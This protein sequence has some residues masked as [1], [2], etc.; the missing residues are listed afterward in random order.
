MAS[1][2]DLKGKG[3]EL[4]ELGTATESD[5]RERRAVEEEQDD[6]DSDLDELDDVLE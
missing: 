6:G 2:T 3:K 5:E 4:P 1:N